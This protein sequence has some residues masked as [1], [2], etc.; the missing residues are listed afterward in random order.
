MIYDCLNESDVLIVQL[1]PDKK[2]VIN[3]LL[4]YHLHVYVIDVL[5]KEKINSCH[6][7]LNQ[8]H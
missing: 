8:V 2:S 5:E 1:V 7:H 6:F 3:L 4:L